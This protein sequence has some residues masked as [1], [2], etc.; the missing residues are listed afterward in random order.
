MS[1]ARNARGSGS[2]GGTLRAALSRAESERAG[3]PRGRHRRHSSLPRAMQASAAEGRAPSVLHPALLKRTEAE[4]PTPDGQAPVV[5]AAAPEASGVADA[6]RCRSASGSSQRPRSRHARGPSQWPSG[7]RWC[8]SPARRARARRWNGAR[9]PSPSWQ[10]SPSRSRCCTA[11][12][13]PPRCWSARRCREGALPALSPALPTPAAARSY[14][15]WRSGLE[16]TSRWAPPPSTQARP[17]SSDRR[18]AQGAGACLSRPAARSP[19]A[20]LAAVRGAGHRAAQGAPPCRCSSVPF[21]TRQLTPHAAH[22]RAER[23]TA[24]L[25]PAGPAVGRGR[26]GGGQGAHG[27]GSASHNAGPRARHIGERSHLLLAG[28]GDPRVR[29]PSVGELKFPLRADEE[30]GA[31]PRRRPPLRHADRARSYRT[32][33]RLQAQP[34]ALVVRPRAVEGTR[35]GRGETRGAALAT[36]PWMSSSLALRAAASRCEPCRTHRTPTS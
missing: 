35:R 9:S 26:P 29:Q 8:L 3:T 32:G 31:P 5:S 23:A 36:S 10:R 24:G 7:H 28:L 20:A 22:A 1:A 13:G 18:R 16:E 19:V 11:G 4:V 6:T 21:R 34:R 14:I 30:E 12:A 33:P 25:V 15:A 2:D 17:C 27:R